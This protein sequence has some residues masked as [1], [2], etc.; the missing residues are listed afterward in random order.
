ML[1]TSP[2]LLA[3][4][5]E[6][7][8]NTGN[9]HPWEHLAS[10]THKD[11]SDH[12]HDASVHKRPRRSDSLLQI[13][14]FDNEQQSHNYTHA[15]ATIDTSNNQDS[16]HLHDDNSNEYGTPIRLEHVQDW[17]GHVYSLGRGVERGYGEG[18]TKR[19]LLHRSDQ[20]GVYAKIIYTVA[21]T[22]MT[23]EPVT[24]I[25]G[26]SDDTSSLMRVTIDHVE[27]KPA[28]RGWHFG[29][30]LIT[31]VIQ[32]VQR[33]YPND[34]IGGRLEAEE[35][36]QRHNRLVQFYEQF[37]F[38][39]RTDIP[40]QYLY[41]R[42][43][44]GKHLRRIPMHMA[45][46]KHPIVDYPRSLFATQF[47]PVQVQ[48]EHGKEV[49]LSSN[50]HATHWLLVQTIMGDMQLRSVQDEVLTVSANGTLSWYQEGKMEA[51]SA[52]CWNLIRLVDNDGSDSNNGGSAKRDESVLWRIQSYSSSP[53]YLAAHDTILTA[54]RSV[55]YWTFDPHKYTLKATSDTPMRRHHERQAVTL[56]TTEF[57]Q[58]M[59]H[60]WCDNINRSC[61]ELSL[62]D[63][64]T[65]A[66]RLASN[67]WSDPPSGPSL[68]TLCFQSAETMRTM[69]HPDW[70]QFV[71]LVFHLARVLTLMDPHAIDNGHDWTLTSTSRVVEDG[72]AS[73]RGKGLLHTPLTWTGPEY[74]FHWMR[75]NQLSLPDEAL[76]LMRLT[77][78]EEWHT[79]GLYVDVSDSADADIQ[80]QCSEL[81]VTLQKVQKETI[82]ELTDDE[83]NGLWKSH[84]ARI[85][86]KFGASGILKW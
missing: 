79:Q 1:H 42:N 72:N 26:S 17:I 53:W 74:M 10:D 21:A 7:A 70:V 62:L 28:V 67:P 82:S 48:D 77:L 32:L 78:L 56:Q 47:V 22:P 15:A 16:M 68:R 5:H 24:P 36:I 54:T 9:R 29:D 8:P 14:A 49:T 61:I 40:V 13:P 83:C 38:T 41:S 58:S 27:V 69:G 35:D 18:Y 31:E 37:G 84:Y 50:G 65:L 11:S 51:G 60:Y 66:T 44:N 80:L 75:R 33:E 76:R 2:T 81:Y 43:D 20:R 34:R 46:Q 3:S 25:L 59:K 73:M 52:S 86:S 19:L 57:I 30:I 85:A 23:S 71:A 6:R 4:G 63:A 45:F 39:V 12:E 55:S 64:L